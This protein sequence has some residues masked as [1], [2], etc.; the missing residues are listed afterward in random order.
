VVSKQEI[1]SATID[2]EVGRRGLGRVVRR[3][4]DE[5]L[6]EEIR[7]LTARFEAVEAGRRMDSEVG[8]DNEEEAIITTDG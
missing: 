3:A 7:I 1:E 8:D 5:G 6:R 2:M 4:V